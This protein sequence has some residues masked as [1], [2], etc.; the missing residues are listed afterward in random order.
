MS[1]V[2]TH[3]ENVNPARQESRER[4]SPVLFNDAI[5]AYRQSFRIDPNNAATWQALGLAYLITGNKTAALDIVREL[6]RLDPTRADKLF[7]SV[8]RADAS[9][10][11][12]VN[13]RGEIPVC[14]LC[15]TS[16]L[17]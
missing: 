9:E 11:E 14:K 13:G 2:L 10:V 7:K 15:A 8:Y 16:V 5:E 17:L 1:G 12:K 4:N 6:R 3:G